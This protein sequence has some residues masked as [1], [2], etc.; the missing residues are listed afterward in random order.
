MP[1][2]GFLQAGSPEPNAQRVAAFRKGLSETGFGDQSVVIE[3]RWAA[4]QA[5]RLPEMAADLVRRPVHVIPTPVSTAAAGAR[6]APTA[7]GH[8]FFRPPPRSPA[9]PV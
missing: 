9:L 7:R 6:Q 1:V 3:F 5:N 4:G 2:I 8:S